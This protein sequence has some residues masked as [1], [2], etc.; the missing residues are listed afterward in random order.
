M[1]LRLATEGQTR[2]LEDA[3]A[4]CRADSRMRG[5]WLSGSF[6]QGVGDEFSDIDL[7]CYTPDED[8]ARVEEDWPEWLS[9]IT[10]AAHSQQFG[11]A[12][13]GAFGLLVITPEWEHLDVWF[14]S[15]TGVEKREDWAGTRPLFDED[16]LLPAAAV[17][18][19]VPGEPWF[20]RTTVDSFFYV[21]GSLAGVVGRGEY[22]LLP[23]GVM[24]MRDQCLVP[25]MHAE[26]GLAPKGGLKRFSQH[27]TSE[28]CDVLAQ[29]PPIRMDMDALVES[30]LW[31]ARVF[32]PRARALAARVRATYPEEFERATLDLLRR[33][34]GVTV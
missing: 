20:P 13:S 23:S 17:P 10:P 11:T 33:T 21:L 27:L 1:T 15:R 19:A 8:L 7:H 9:A 4:A 6:G 31:L 14:F 12:A 29:M 22:L 18:A 30:H 24:A 25:L 2:L 34:L 3:L 28:Q 16:G 5:A 26:R 32:I